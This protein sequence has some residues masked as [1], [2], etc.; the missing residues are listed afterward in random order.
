MKR[1]AL[2]AVTL[3]ALPLFAQQQPHNDFQVFAYLSDVGISWNESNGAVADANFGIAVSK[4][5]SPRVS[6]ELSVTKQ[7]WW[8]YEPGPFVLGQPVVRF[9]HTV[10]PISLDGQYHFLTDSRWKPYLG[11]GVRYVQPNAQLRDISPRISPEINGGVAFMATPRLSI[12][13]DAKQALRSQGGPGY[14]PGSRISVGV[15]WHF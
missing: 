3:F 8:E 10:Y 5:V 15:G 12:R 2:F 9:K 13:F 11:A 7:G 1:L 14:D 4:F 6:V